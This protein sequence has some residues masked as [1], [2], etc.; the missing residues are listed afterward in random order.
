MPDGRAPP[1]QSDRKQA[2]AQAHLKRCRKKLL[3]EKKSFQV[4]EAQNQ[5]Q[6][7]AGQH[8]ATHAADSRLAWFYR[9]CFNHLLK[10]VEMTGWTWEH[11]PVPGIREKWHVAVRAAHQGLKSWIRRRKRILQAQK[12]ASKRSKGVEKRSASANACS[13]RTTSNSSSSKKACTQSEKQIV[14]VELLDMRENFLA[15]KDDNI[16]CPGQRK[17]TRAA[18]DELSTFYRLYGDDLSRDKRM[19]GACPSCT[20]ITPDAWW[21]KVHKAHHQLKLWMRRRRDHRD[22]KSGSFSWR[23]NRFLHFPSK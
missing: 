23:K 12:Q 20:N 17:A 16:S 7:Y 11:L 8:E 15:W 5:S 3:K 6:R 22:Y 19:E 18:E 4:W 1:N 13:Q 2:I 9:E 21:C 10:D 14:R